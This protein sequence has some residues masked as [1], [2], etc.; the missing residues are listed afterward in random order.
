M[1]T[2][3]CDDGLPLWVSLYSLIIWMDPFLSWRHLC[4]IFN[5]FVNTKSYI[6]DKSFCFFLT[7]VIGGRIIGLKC[8]KTLFFYLK[9]M[10]YLLKKYFLI[11]NLR[12][13]KFPKMQTNK[14][15]SR[16]PGNT[17]TVNDYNL[18]WIHVRKAL[19]GKDQNICLFH[20]SSR[21]KFCSW[22][23]MEQ[24]K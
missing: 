15:Y 12:W 4:L 16:S 8:R 9:K 13:S 7:F 5:K 21:T 6:Q 10:D 23:R 22:K 19:Q 17:S 1:L 24:I 18:S 14:K 2:W 11:K 20:C 3:H